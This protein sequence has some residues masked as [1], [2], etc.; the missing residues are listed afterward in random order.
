[1]R[2]RC[3]AC[4]RHLGACHTIFAVEG[5][6]YCS[7]DCA[8]KDLRDKYGLEAVTKFQQLHEEVNPQDIGIEPVNKV[9]DILCRR[10][11]ISFEEAEAKV[12][13]VRELLS[14]VNGSYDSAEEIMANELGL[15]MDYIMDIL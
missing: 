15:E 4:T 2:S 9:V 14:E 1:M 8:T 12:S 5:I 10:D 13:E 3:N 7:A 6:L 11:N